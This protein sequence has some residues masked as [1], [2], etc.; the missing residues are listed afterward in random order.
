MRLGLRDGYSKIPELQT[1][2]SVMVRPADDSL[3]TLI[4]TLEAIYARCQYHGRG[5]W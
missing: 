4:E 5:Q 2:A 1:D 3:A